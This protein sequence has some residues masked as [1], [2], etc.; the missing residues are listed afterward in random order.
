MPTEREVALEAELRAAKRVIDTLIR[1]VERQQQPDAMVPA[2]LA[3]LQAF[4]SIEALAD[5]RTRELHAS[6]A[7]YRALFQGSPDM[8]FTVDAQGDIT[9]VNQ[10]G[11]E[12]FDCEAAAL[13]GLQTGDVVSADRCAFVLGHPDGGLRGVPRTARVVAALTKVRP[14]PPA[15]AAEHIRDVLSGHDRIGQVVTVPYR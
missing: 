9:A 14:G 4:A 8:V 15:A 1:R 3:A 7:R 13:T 6:E 5:Q 12:A 11:L 10:T 2:Q